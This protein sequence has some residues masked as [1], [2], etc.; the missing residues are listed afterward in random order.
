MTWFGKCW[1]EFKE[2]AIKGNAVDLAVGVIIGAAFGSIVT[3][4][5]KDIVMPPISLLTG[6]LDFSNKF[7]VLR[8]AKDGSVAFHT[9]ADAVKAGAIT[10]N[11]GNFVT[12]LINFLI[13]AGAVFLLVRAINRMKQPKHADPVTKDCPA[14]AM[15]IPVKATRCPH[16][17]TEFS[18]QTR[19]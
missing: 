14:C 16:C 18:G 13:V 9:P 3:S 1:K 17:T 5:V 15:T 11:Y 8:A 12:L 2:F 19:G 10:W 4:L 7:I 6:G